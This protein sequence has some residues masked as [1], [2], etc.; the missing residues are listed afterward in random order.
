MRVVFDTNVLISALAFPGGAPTDVFMLACTHHVQ[1]FASPAILAE[2]AGVLRRK[3]GL[4]EDQVAALVG[5]VTDA[6]RLVVPRT[7]V[8]Q[9][10]SHPADNRVLEL[11]LEAEADYV[12]TGDMRHVRPLD[13]WRGIRIRTPREFLDEVTGT[14][15]DTGG[16]SL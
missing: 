2:F 12:V 8:E 1:A 13:Q 3:L 16:D 5:D 14:S 10:H 6:C 7:C 4:S 15:T 9:I 11:A